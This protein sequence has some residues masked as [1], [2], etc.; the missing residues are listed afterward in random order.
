MPLGSEFEDYAK[1]I[2]ITMQMLEILV[3]KSFSIAEYV[4]K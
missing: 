4:R 3:L 2:A 1:L